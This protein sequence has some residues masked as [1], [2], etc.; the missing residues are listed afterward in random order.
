MRADRNKVHAFV[1]QI[2]ERF[3]PE[4]IILFGSE[5]RGEA[6]LNSDVDLLVVMPDGGDPLGKSIEIV[7]ALPHD[8]F[9]LDLIVRD[10]DVLKWRI[11]NEDWFLREIMEQG[12]VLYEAGHTGVGAKS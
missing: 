11:D 10:P 7:R 5:A 12:I 9:S 3:R 4:K 2:A 8:G 6:G 1:D